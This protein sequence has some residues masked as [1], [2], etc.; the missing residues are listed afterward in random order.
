MERLWSGR[1]KMPINRDGFTTKVK[2]CNMKFYLTVNFYPETFLPGEIFI[3]I[4][5][6]GSTISGFVDSLAM[7]ISVALQCGVQWASLREL[8]LYHKFEPN[9]DKNSSLVHAI[10]LA[11]DDII[12]KRKSLYGTTEVHDPSVHVSK[13]N[14]NSISS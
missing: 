3:Q 9:D 7:T 14:E 10:A 13:K 12:E 1:R 4:A 2:A 6:Q 8:Y 5:K 11:V